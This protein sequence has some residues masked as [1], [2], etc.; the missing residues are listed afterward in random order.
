[1]T[2]VQHLTFSDFVGINNQLASGASTIA[3]QEGHLF[4][5]HV[6]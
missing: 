1:M 4:V 2:D 3:Q 5:L 6:A